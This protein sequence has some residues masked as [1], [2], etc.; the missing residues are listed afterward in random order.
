[1]KKTFALIGIVV[2]ALFILVGLF[3]IGGAFDDGFSSAYS[4]G[5]YDSGYASFGGDYYTYSNNN[6][7]EAAEAAR[8]A[9]RNLRTLG[10]ILCKMFGFLFMGLGGMG[11]CRFGLAYSECCTQKPA[12]SPIPGAPAWEPPSE[13]PAAPVEEAEKP[14]E[15]ENHVL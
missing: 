4:N 10:G 6:A 7:A 12:L 3:A 2:C 15:E 5:M 11:L 1:M 8:A 9:V 13:T 14:C